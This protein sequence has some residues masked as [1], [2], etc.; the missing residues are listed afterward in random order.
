VVIDELM[1]HPVDSNEEYV[2]LYN[3]GTQAV[4]LSTADRVWRLDGAVN[5]DFPLGLSLPAGGRLVVVGFDPAVETSR[6]AAFTA[7]YATGPLAAGTKI[8]GPW[9]GNLSNRGERVALEKSQPGADGDPR[10]WVVLDEVI[11]SDVSPWPA[12]PDGQGDAL[13]RRAADPTRSGNDPANWHP[14]APTP[15]RP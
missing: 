1:Y 3:P 6:L 12:G 5:Y 13:Q 10:V 14:A 11:Y 2:E 4:S 7:A 8:V 15:G 9:Q